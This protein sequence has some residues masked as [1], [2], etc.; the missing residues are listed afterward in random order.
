M[1]FFIPFLLFLLFL[2]PNSIK[3]QLILYK[4]APRLFSFF[5]AHF[6]HKEFEHLLSNVILYKLLVI[7][8]YLLNFHAEQRRN[9]YLM[10]FLIFLPLPFL[11]ST[12][13][14]STPS[15]SYLGFSGIVSAFLGFLPYSALIYFKKSLNWEAG[16]SNFLN[17][18]LYSSLG[19]VLLTYFEF[20]PIKIISSMIILVAL[21]FVIFVTV[22]K[23]LLL[24]FAYLR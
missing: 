14:L 1:A 3:D 17:I 4:N 19:F 21:I 24:R 12:I 2:L 9:F 10:A 8:V 5:T 13:D 7:P 16:I 18:V 11:L 20:T 23:T 22:S 6:V 15:S